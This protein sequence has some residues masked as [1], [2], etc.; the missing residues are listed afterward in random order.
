LRKSIGL[1]EAFDR[2]NVQALGLNQ[3]RRTHGTA[4]KLIKRRGQGGSMLRRFGRARGNG[5]EWQP[6]RRPRTNYSTFEG[7]FG[8]RRPRARVSSWTLYLDIWA[9]DGRAPKMGFS[10]FIFLKQLKSRT[11]RNAEVESPFVR[12][13]TPHL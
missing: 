11:W 10:K 13:R 9:E 7:S 3:P 12:K 6:R 1:A 4:A 8:G 2:I 5:R